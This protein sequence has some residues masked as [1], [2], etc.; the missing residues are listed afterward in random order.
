VRGKFISFML[1]YSQI[2]ERLCALNMGAKLMR[3]RRRLTPDTTPRLFLSIWEQS[4]I[5]AK[6][7]ASDFVS[8]DAAWD[9]IQC[10]VRLS[11]STRPVMWNGRTAASS[12]NTPQSRRRSA[13]NQQRQK[14]PLPR[15]TPAESER[16]C[17]KLVY[18]II[19]DKKYIVDGA[20][21]VCT[22]IKV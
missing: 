4:R 10:G 17:S 19:V 20:L 8:A 13:C 2:H 1:Q 22:P 18:Q 15:A 16:K 21:P 12:A 9:Q 3:R 6:V 14:T 11:R 7:I 5:I